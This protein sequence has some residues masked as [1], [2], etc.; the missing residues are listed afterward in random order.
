MSRVAAIKT[1]VKNDV[2]NVS[3]RYAT[4]RPPY[5]AA[6]GS[7]NSDPPTINPPNSV[8]R[9]ATPERPPTSGSTS[10]FG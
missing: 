1:A 2:M 4:K 8:K 9:K 5:N 7:S 6:P 10:N 3:T